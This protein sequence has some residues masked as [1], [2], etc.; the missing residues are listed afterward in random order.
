M[1]QSYWSVQIFSCHYICLPPIPDSAWSKAWV[2]GRSL[3]G[4][5][6]SNPVVAWMSVS[7]GCCVLSG[8]GLR[9]GPITR[10]EECPTVCVCVCVCDFENSTM[11]RSRLIRADEP[12]KQIST[13]SLSMVILQDIQI[14]TN[15]AVYPLTL[16]Y[17]PFLI[18]FS[19]SL[20][21]CSR[22]RI[23]CLLFYTSLI[24]AY[25]YVLRVVRISFSQTV[26]IL[27]F[28]FLLWFSLFY[29]NKS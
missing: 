9:D 26:F 17:R 23:T 7:C 14:Y 1:T 18:I 10:P 27:D 13:A 2:C 20:N 29:T 8:R 28:T 22:V 21:L 4:M 3:A 5:A 12:W 6:G 11:R 24:R 25:T 16:N 19:Q 15:F